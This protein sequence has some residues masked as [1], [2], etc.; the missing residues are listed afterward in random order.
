[1]KFADGEKNTNMGIV[2]NTDGSLPKMDQNY[3]LRDGVTD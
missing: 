3:S 2:D 1:M